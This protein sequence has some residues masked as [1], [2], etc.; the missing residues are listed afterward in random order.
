MKLCC[1]MGLS[2]QKQSQKSRSRFLFLKLEESEGTYCLYCLSFLLSV[3]LLVT[4]A[5]SQEQCM[6]EFLWI[7]H[8]KLAEPCFSFL[9]QV[10]S[11]FQVSLWLFSF[12]LSPL[13]KLCPFAEGHN[14]SLSATYFKKINYARDL[15]F[16]LTVDWR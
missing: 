4:H 5:V 12:K 8:Q 15:E 11:P 16:G 7:H 2:L 6:T 14:E 1:K 3:H 10:V 13:F 9:V